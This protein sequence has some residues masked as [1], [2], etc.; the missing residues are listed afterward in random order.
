MDPIDIR[1]SSGILA[2]MTMDLREVS[3]SQLLRDP[4]SVTDDLGES[5]VIIRRRDGDDFVVEGLE[6]HN[7]EMLAT[8]ILAASLKDAPGDTIHQMAVRIMER[9][10]W[11]RYLPDEDQDLFVEELIGCVTAG[12]SLGG[13][14]ELPM[15]IQQW[16][17]TAEI[18]ADEIL[19]SQLSRP[20]DE[21][22][23]QVVPPPI[24]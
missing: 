14:S 16:R 24:G 15:L 3:L 23:D 18:H 6:R 2:T 11:L 4:K 13:F 10:P 1:T 5:A 19:A 7:R 9:L 22:L 12:A 21:P 8:E 17:T 20:I